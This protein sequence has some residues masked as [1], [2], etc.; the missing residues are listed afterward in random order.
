MLVAC[1]SPLLGKVGSRK[2]ITP[3][4]SAKFLNLSTTR[5]PNRIVQGIPRPFSRIALRRSRSR[6]A[7]AQDGYRTRGFGHVHVRLH[8]RMGTPSETARFPRTC[9]GQRERSRILDMALQACDFALF[10]R[11]LERRLHERLA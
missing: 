8:V 9:A 11:A 6:R 2:I 4:E 3:A 1:L 7:A 10:P 5:F